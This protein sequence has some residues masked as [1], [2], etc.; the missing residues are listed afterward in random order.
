MG[1]RRQIL[2]LVAT[3]GFAA[4][5]NAWAPA[6]RA[7]GV[8]RLVFVHGRGQAPDDAQ[9]KKCGEP[10]FDGPTLKGDWTKDLKA[11]LT[12]SGAALPSG[13]DIVF[14]FYGCKLQE[15]V[16]QSQLPMSADLLAHGGSTDDEYLD[17][18]AEM[19]QT[20]AAHAG[21]TQEDIEREFGDDPTPH[22]PEN[23]KWVIATVRAIDKRVPG[24]SAAFLEAFLRDV[25]LYCRF[26]KVR[27]DIDGIVRAAISPEPS[28]I[29]AH[30]LGTV[31]AYNV[32][33]NDQRGLTAPLFVTVGCPLA[34]RAIRKTLAP[35]S[36]PQPVGTWYNA[37]DPKDIVAL[38]P[39]DNNSFSIGRAIE[40]N[41]TVANFTENHHGIEGY[42]GDR[43]VAQRV[44]TGLT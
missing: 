29:V 41:G 6:V 43:V 27:A 9:A 10:P 4:L 14:P 42:L 15:Y 36:D 17:F 20:F 1:T 24:L 31:V 40:N 8:R 33:R 12:A 38:N 28:V 22:G 32:L 19:A 39:L 44:A 2:T 18:R 23:F 30:S 7:A 26:P 3:T 11:G 25:Y 5:T 34:I 35:L 13:L 21:V 37:F 16:I